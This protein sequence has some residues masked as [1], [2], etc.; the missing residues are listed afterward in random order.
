MA[1]EWLD[2]AIGIVAPQTALRRARARHAFEE[3]TRS[4]SGAA[5]GRNT[6][7]WHVQSTSADAE[8]YFAG[9][10][11]RDRH[12]D[13]VRNNAHA[14][15]AVAVLANN[16]IGEGIIPRPNTG[17]EARNKVIKD[18]WDQFAAECD[19]EKQLDFYGMQTLAVREMIEGGEVMIRR[20]R[21]RK[22][23]KTAIPLQLQILEGDFLD[24]S[25]TGD[26]EKGYV[27]VDGIQFVV[28]P[29]SQGTGPRQGYWLWH[30]HPGN[31]F[32]FMQQSVVSS[33]VPATEILH[34]YEKQRTQVRGVPWGAPVIRALRDLDDYE[35]A[36][37]RRKAD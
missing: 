9:H 24:N 36:E 35:F 27:N 31:N 23:A 26:F 30:Q 13:L 12:R 5:L 34:L 7:G 8:I 17:D 20:R 28:S 1:G 14:A 37:I 11:L 21:L 19:S 15:K 16:I 4:Y 18:L 25:R 6:D 10:R 32:I 33:I 29:D 2:R 22:S 3:A